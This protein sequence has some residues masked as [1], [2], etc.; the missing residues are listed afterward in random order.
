GLVAQARLGLP[1]LG[2][3]PRLAPDD[4]LRL[5]RS[6]GDVPRLPN[7]GFQLP[8]VGYYF[9]SLPK[10]GALPELLPRIDL[11]PVAAYAN[12]LGAS[13]LNGVDIT[14]PTRG[15]L[16][17]LLP[18][19]LINFDLSKVFPNIAGLKLDGLF[20]NLRLPSAAN[21]G[22][23]V[24]HGLDEG[25]RSAWLQV[26]A[27]VPFQQPITMLDIAGLRL[28]VGRARFRAT[29]RMEAQLG[30]SPRQRTRGSIRGDWQLSAGGRPLV[31][32]H[33]CTLEFDEGNRITFDVSPARVRLKPPLDF[34]TRLLEP[35]SSSKN[36]LRVAVKPT[37]VVTTLS[38][39]IPNVQ[40]GSFGI[41]NLSL[42]LLF[43]VDVMPQFRLRAAVAVADENRPFTLTVFVL[44]GAGHFRT[45]LAYRPSDG[46]FST[47]VSVAIY[48]SASLAISLGVVSGGIYA[49]FGVVV[50]YA[51]N[52]RSGGSL[53]MTLRILFVGEV[54]LLGFLSI[55]LTLGL[56][57]SYGEGNE[58]I[59]RGFVR[60]SIKIGW[61]ITINVDAAVQYNFARSS[62]SSSSSSEIQTAAD[63][64][65]DLF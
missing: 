21:E 8:Q 59:G 36:G 19:D 14:L 49:Y 22:L 38:L 27:D 47:E 48:A 18:E 63:Q 41:A 57:A 9:F 61:F 29:A 65:V 45:A 23:R 30:Q 39:P 37:G 58:L 42:G 10:S 51:A 53:T 43:A 17:R 33:D 12:Q 5:L 16:E 56:E 28:D 46:L 13:L 20:R 11:S 62:G 52:N 26:D 6:F 31:E 35:F 34:L 1:D 4:A 44:G 64:Y 50:T 24:T 54:C 2:T 60:C 40:A 3:P 32:L 25:S 55:G 15:L 7:L